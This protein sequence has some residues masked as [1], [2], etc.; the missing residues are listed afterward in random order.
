[1]ANPRLAQ[2]DIGWCLLFIALFLP[3]MGGSMFIGAA[4]LTPAVLGTPNSVPRQGVE[5]LVEFG[6]LFGSMA[7]GMCIAII[8]FCFLT[9]QYLSVESYE[10]WVRQFESGATKFS[11]AQLAL[12]RYLLKRM[13]PHNRGNAL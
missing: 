4:Y 10:R 13:Q 11:R 2:S 7:F 3:L 9:R 6:F 8:I 5:K 1:M 12:G